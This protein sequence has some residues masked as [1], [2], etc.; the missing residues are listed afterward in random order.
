M[1]A[2]L[3]SLIGKMLQ[4]DD[5]VSACLAVQ[6]LSSVIGQV[7]EE[8]AGLVR[9]LV[10]PSLVA[11]RRCIDVDENVACDAMDILEE[12]TES[13]LGLLKVLVTDLCMFGLQID[14]HDPPLVNE[15]RM[16]AWSF[17]HH[18]VNSRPKTLVKKKLL[19]PILQQIAHCLERDSDVFTEVGVP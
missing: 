17:I 11:I 2:S 12:C 3:L 7:E 19:V 1:H 16:K 15:A 10:A 6:C 14:A 5:A 8:N 18:L 13:D 4:D 9:G